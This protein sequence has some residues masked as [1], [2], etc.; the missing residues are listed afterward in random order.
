M[1]MQ[2]S[3]WKR[4]VITVVQVILA[5]LYWTD[6]LDATCTTDTTGLETCT[7]DDD[8]TLK[9]ASIIV[10]LVT[11]ALACFAFMFAFVCYPCFRYLFLGSGTRSD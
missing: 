11:A 7:S 8:F 10:K 4:L 3:D 6:E 2:Y 1:L 9:D 5:L